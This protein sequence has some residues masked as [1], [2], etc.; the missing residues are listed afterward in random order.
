V[1]PLLQWFLPSRSAFGTQSLPARTRDRIGSHPLLQRNTSDSGSP[2]TS[3]RGR[4]QELMKLFQARTKRQ[5][6]QASHLFKAAGQRKT[7]L[8]FPSKPIWVL[9]NTD[10]ER[11]FNPQTGTSSMQY[12]RCVD[13]AYCT[14][15]CGVEHRNRQRRL[16]ISEW[17]PCRR[18]HRP[19]LQGPT[20]PQATLR[21]VSSRNPVHPELL[22]AESS[23][24]RDYATPAEYPPSF[25]TAALE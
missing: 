18:G 16:Q 14:E 1:P 7:T 19:R 4:L 20:S 23:S 22:P 2:G 9:F 10:G 5:P 21:G 12:Q 11:L 17:S 15:K 3:W 13:P 25:E 8:R 24:I 6:H